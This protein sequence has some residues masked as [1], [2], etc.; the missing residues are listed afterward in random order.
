MSEAIEFEDWLFEGLGLLS[1]RF[2]VEEEGVACAD[3]AGDWFESGDAVP[4]EGSPPFF[5][6]LLLSLSLARD[7]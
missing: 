1:T 5:F 7:S 4:E 6:D 3:P 2:C